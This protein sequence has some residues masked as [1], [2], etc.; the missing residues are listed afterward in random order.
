[1]NGDVIS[2][3][4]IG[5]GGSGAARGSSDIASLG[6]LGLI[7]FHWGITSS[8]GGR[9]SGPSLVCFI[10]T[11]CGYWCEM[12]FCKE[13]KQQNYTWPDINQNLQ[14]REVS[15][16]A[17][18]R[19]MARQL[20]NKSVKIQ[21]LIRSIHSIDMYVALQRTCIWYTEYTMFSHARH[22]RINY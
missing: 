21:I 11:G 18:S 17:L 22:Q 10:H 19:N 14:I 1:M 16:V 3:H 12:L 7:S 5:L 15:R 9:S 6:T 2:T 13:A 8:G 20:S 4:C